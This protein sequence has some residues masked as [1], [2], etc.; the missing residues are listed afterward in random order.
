MTR[1]KMTDKRIELGYMSVLKNVIGL[2]SA[3]QKSRI[4]KCF[5][6]DYKQLRRILKVKWSRFKLS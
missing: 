3:V 4:W 2:Y 1:S 5:G 6:N